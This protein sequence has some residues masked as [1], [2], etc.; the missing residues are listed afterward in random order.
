MPVVATGEVHVILDCK[1]QSGEKIIDMHKGERDP[2]TNAIRRPGSRHV[3]T[4]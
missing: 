3:V 2:G 4:C 1:D